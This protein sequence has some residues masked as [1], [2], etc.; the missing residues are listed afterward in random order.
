VTALGG[1]DGV[2][3]RQPVDRNVV[4]GIGKTRSRLPRHRSFPRVGVAVPCRGDDGIEFALQRRESGVLEAA[5]IAPFELL[6]RQFYGRHPL[7]DFRRHQSNLNNLEQSPQ[8]GF[9]AAVGGGVPG[10]LSA[11]NCAAF[12]HE[13]VSAGL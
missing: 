3:R 7:A 10:A 2:A 11:R 13:L 5:A 8:Q 6:P 12:I 1:K 9:N 4:V